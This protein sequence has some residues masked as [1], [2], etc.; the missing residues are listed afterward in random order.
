[1]LGDMTVQRTDNVGIVFDDLATAI[2]FFI[3]LGL[4]L[5]G[6]MPVEGPWVDRVVGLDGVR[7][8]IVIMR[9]PDG[10][11]WLELTK[12]HRPTAISADVSG[13]ALS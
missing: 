9:A 5:E 1:M 6:E 10:H 11:S 2:A 12:F 4:E 7:V 13:V 3:E 8:D